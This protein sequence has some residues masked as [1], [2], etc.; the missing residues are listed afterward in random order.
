MKY[1]LRY[2][3][4]HNPWITTHSGCTN[5][6]RD[7]IWVEIYKNTFTDDANRFWTSVHLRSVSG[8]VWGNTSA[9]PL[10][11]GFGIYIDHERSYA[12]CSGPYGPMCNGTRAW[13]EN[14][15][16][17]GYRCLGQPGWGQPQASNMSAATFQ[18]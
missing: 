2:N 3:T 12:S 15:G 13:D 5:G 16:L 4:I 7:P 9:V 17:H 8:L 6:G 18:G 14:A 1:V 10:N 11:N